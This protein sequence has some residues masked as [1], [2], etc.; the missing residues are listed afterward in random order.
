MSWPEMHGAVTHFPVALLITAFVYEAGA[1]VLHRP[2]WQTVSFWM[3]VAA[4]VMAVP[5]LV[6]GWIT[7]NELFSG[8]ARPPAVF[9]WHRAAAFTTSGV[10]LLVLL[11]RALARDRLAGGAGIGSVAAT[12]VAAAVVGYTG[13][14][15]GVMTLGSQTP[16]G[17]A[18]AA[19]AVPKDHGLGRHLFE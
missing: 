19:P 16:A 4:V 10:A 12:L 8:V 17:P 6:A 13:Y 9:I 7:G 1:M 11:W 18:G 14:L 2:A 15:G 3:I 5:S